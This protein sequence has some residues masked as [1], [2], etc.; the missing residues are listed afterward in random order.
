MTGKIEIIK[1]WYRCYTN[2]KTRCSELEAIELL[3]RLEEKE[4]DLPASGT[5]AF[6]ASEQLRMLVQGFKAGY[7]EGF[8]DGIEIGHIEGIERGT[9]DTIKELRKK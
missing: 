6:S 3:R 8:E 1:E 2:G 9:A 5:A 4:V 7:V